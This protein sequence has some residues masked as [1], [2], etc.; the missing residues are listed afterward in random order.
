MGAASVFA[1]RL[2]GVTANGAR[3]CVRS[4]QSLHLFARFGGKAEDWRT[5]NALFRG[6]RA[7][8]EYPKRWI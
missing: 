8:A 2:N 4:A 3:Q 1:V 6:H 5:T 7:A